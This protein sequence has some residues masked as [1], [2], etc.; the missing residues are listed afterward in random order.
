MAREITRIHI[1]S[2]VHGVGLSL[3]FFIFSSLYPDKWQTY[4]SRVPKRS[5]NQAVFSRTHEKKRLTSLY[6]YTLSSMSVH[7]IFFLEK[8]SHTSGCRY[9]YAHLSVSVLLVLIEYLFSAS[10]PILLEIY[11]GYIIKKIWITVSENNVLASAVSCCHLTHICN[12][13]FVLQDLSL[14]YEHPLFTNIGNRI[15]FFH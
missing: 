15:L 14:C 11:A 7:V 12:L 6:V 1:F 3:S 8:R 4:S 9:L 2:P 13:L 10:V 5:W